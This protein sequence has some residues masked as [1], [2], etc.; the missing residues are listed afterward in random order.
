MSKNYNLWHTT[1]CTVLVM[2]ALA[3]AGGRA[4]AQTTTQRPWSAG[5]STAQ[6]K[7]AEALYQEGNR[8]FNNGF[9]AGAT[10]KYQEALQHWNHP[11]IHYNLA[12]A[13]ISLD[14]PI[15]AY[16]SILV[17]LRHGVDALSPEEHQRAIDYARMLRQ[18][19]ATVEV[20]CDEPGAVVT[21]DGKPLLTGPGR[22]T[23]RVLPGKHQVVASKVGHL[24][25]SKAFTL[26]GAA[27]SRVELRPPAVDQPSVRIQ[28]RRPAWTHWTVTGLGLGAGIA[29]VM[30]HWE[31]YDEHVRYRDGWQR[32]AGYAGYATAG[33]LLVAGTALA[34]MNRPQPGEAGLRWPAWT[35]W[36][37]TGLGLGAGAAAAMLLWDF[38]VDIREREREGES[39]RDG[40]R[41]GWQRK[42]GYAGYATAGALWVAGTVLASLNRPQPLKTGGRPKAVQLSAGGP[43]GSP[44]I[45]VHV[46]F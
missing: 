37:V 19:I 21:L 8:D 9:F 31:L 14:R 15:Q 34:S 25:T 30:L 36:T 26:A 16:E 28:Q 1:S 12:L 32:K 5:V 13:L 4:W 38:D 27:R 44:G 42:A 46:P 10:A 17:A 6:Q 3:L 39:A 35:H 29:A 33:A 11:G 7:L 40:L 43:A 45:S 41:Y 20:V 24:T 2:A 18:R 23:T 22:V